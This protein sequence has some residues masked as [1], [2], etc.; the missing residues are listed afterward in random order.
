MQHTV[1]LAATTGLGTGADLKTWVLLIGGNIF[2]CVLVV[3]LIGDFAKR[4]WGDLIG[5]FIAAVF[6]AGCIYYPD[7]MV[8]V[9]QTLWTKVSGGN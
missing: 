2:I 6:V 3:R 8:T 4:A 7:Q 5:T 1:Q 9:F